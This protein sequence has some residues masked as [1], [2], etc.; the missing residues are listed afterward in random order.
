MSCAST[1]GPQNSPEA[2]YKNLNS[3]NSGAVCYSQDLENESEILYC[4][5]HG[6]IIVMPC[7]VFSIQH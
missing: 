7:T 1:S 4:T 6:R 2:I 3:W 5:L